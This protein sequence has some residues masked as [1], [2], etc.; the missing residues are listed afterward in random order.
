[1]EEG[2]EELT[3]AGTT[4]GLAQL[5]FLYVLALF[6]KT[7]Y[8]NTPN[9]LLYRQDLFQI[10]VEQTHKHRKLHQRADPFDTIFRLDL[11]I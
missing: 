9:S 3:V 6:C 5:A 1:L 7:A 2:R 4:V 10:I 8:G 11:F